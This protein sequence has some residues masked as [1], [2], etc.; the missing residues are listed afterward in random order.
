MNA[1]FYYENMN[2]SCKRM[3]DKLTGALAA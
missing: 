2:C 1:L 3:C